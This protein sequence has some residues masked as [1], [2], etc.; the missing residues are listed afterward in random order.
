[1][2]DCGGPERTFERAEV[3]RAQGTCQGAEVCVWPV[4]EGVEGR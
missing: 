2:T 1:M 4:R 3:M